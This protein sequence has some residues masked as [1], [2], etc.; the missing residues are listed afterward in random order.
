MKESR[1]TKTRDGKL[2]WVRSNFGF[3][4]L[5]ADSRT[6][7]CETVGKKTMDEQIANAQLI[8]AAPIMLK[9]LLEWEEAS[10]CGDAEMLSQA[11]ISKR[12][13]I[14]KALGL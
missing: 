10:I 11:R 14:K 8:A 4:V 3:Q 2:E 5:T 13:A 7:I 12:I 6:P 9:A 1:A